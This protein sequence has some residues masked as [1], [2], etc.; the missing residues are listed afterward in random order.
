VSFFKFHLNIGGNVR[1]E[2]VREEE[3][4]GGMTK[5]EM[6]REYTQI[7]STASRGA[8][9]YTTDRAKAVTLL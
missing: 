4:S 2:I 3:L 6:S 8:E 1:R 9:S 5:G 7:Y